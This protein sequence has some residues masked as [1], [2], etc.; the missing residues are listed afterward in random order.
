VKL[1]ITGS[2]SFIGK[3]LKRRCFEQGVQAAGIDVASSPMPG[4]IQM[5]ICSPDLE[6]AI[7]ENADALIHLAAVS[8]DKACRE[9]TKLAF[10]VNVGGTINLIRAAKSKG[11]KQFIFASSEWV[12]GEVANAGTQTEDTPID[13]NRLS[14]E[15][16]LT[17]IAGERLLSIANARCGLAVTVLRF[18][19]VYGPRP[20]NWSAVE[21]LFSAV[22]TKETIE[23]G[24]VRTARRF[25]HV[26]DICSGILAALGRTGYEVFNLS[27]NALI[28]L[29]AIIEQSGEIL[30]RRPRVIEKNPSAVSIRNPDNANARAALNWEP[31]IGLREG[32]STL[33]PNC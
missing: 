1:I 19:I 6:Q 14:S 25:I 8:T 32:L 16:A 13:V 11:V 18:G 22:R 17:K 24:S 3:E 21:Q 2:E 20:S 23:V 10:E 7:P 15:Y 5:S 12:Y 33:L 27:G 26:S 29:S 28:P 30:G 9:D 4:H 31:V